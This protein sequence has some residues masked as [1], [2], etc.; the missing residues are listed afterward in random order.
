MKAIAILC[1]IGLA[2]CAPPEIQESEAN[3]SEETTHHIIE[4]VTTALPETTHHPITEIEVGEYFLNDPTVPEI[5]CI[6]AKFSAQITLSYQ[7]S[8][9]GER[10]ASIRVP[11]DSKTRGECENFLEL[12]W[13][14]PASKRRSD[15]IAENTLRLDVARDAEKDVY[16]VSAVTFSLLRDDAVLPEI[17]P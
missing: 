14:N 7:I 13:S 3:V 11:I 4:N 6:K 9:G 8:E 2:I 17:V 1:F 5:H 12:A 15:T 16:Y 10:N